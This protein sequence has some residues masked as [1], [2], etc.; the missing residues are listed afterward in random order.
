MVALSDE[1]R[2]KQLPTTEEWLAF[3]RVVEENGGKTIIIDETYWHNALTRCK[4]V[5]KDIPIFASYDDSD[6]TGAILSIDKNVYNVERTEPTD[7]SEGS[8][9]LEKVDELSSKWVF[10]KDYAHTNITASVSSYSY[11]KYINNEK[12]LIE[13]KILYEAICCPITRHHLY[14]RDLNELVLIFKGQLMG[15]NSGSP[16]RRVESVA[17]NYNDTALKDSHGSFIKRTAPVI[18]LLLRMSLNDIA[19]ADNLAERIQEIALP[20]S[21]DYVAVKLID[22]SYY[23]VHK[24]EELTPEFESYISAYYPVITYE[25]TKDI[26]SNIPKIEVQVAVMGLG[27]ASTGILD[28]LCRSDWFN[29]YLFCD[30]DY[31]EDKNLRNQWYIRNHIGQSKCQA[32]RTQMGCI[33]NLSSTEVILKQCRFQDA[34]LS[35]YNFK[36][37]ISGFDSIECRL[38][39][40]QNIIDGKVRAKYLIDTRYDDLNSSIFLIDLANEEEVAYYKAGLEQDKEAFDKIIAEKQIKNVDEFLAFLEAHDVYHQG[41]SLL[42]KSI[43]ATAMEEACSGNFAC[44]TEECREHFKA[45]WEAHQEEIKKNCLPQEESSCV[46][47]NFIDIYKFTSSFVFAGIRGIEEDEKKL[48][49]H[50]EATTNEIPRSIILRK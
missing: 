38:E 18:Q 11:R 42:H 28:Q 17:N 13:Y 33:R 35:A 14:Y 1:T 23:T 27:S 44:N 40:L 25:Q 36:Y 12:Q 19:Q 10:N 9:H 22:D 26:L 37:I 2:F 30:F 31:V 21:D 15:Q 49:T 41:C 43:G 24:K 32:S 47:Q 16:F 45:L 46:R 5:V 20:P 34:S 3:R 29:K 48:F 6:R 8:E 50:I 39:L 4:G 7:D